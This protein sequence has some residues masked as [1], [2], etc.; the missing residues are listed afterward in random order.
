MD[1]SKSIQ[2]FQIW[3]LQSLDSSGTRLDKFLAHDETH[4]GQMSKW[5]WLCTPSDI[6]KST[7]RRM[8]K[9][10]PAVSE[11]YI[12]QTLEPAADIMIS[13]MIFPVSPDSCMVLAPQIKKCLAQSLIWT[14]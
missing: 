8:E 7:E 11:I 9:I 12:P 4:K 1:R 2:R 13:L 10:H 5:P 3:V 6:D 14:H